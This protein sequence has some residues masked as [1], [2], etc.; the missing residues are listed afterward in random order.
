MKDDLIATHPLPSRPGNWWVINGKLV[1][2]PEGEAPAE[3]RG[4]KADESPLIENEN[5]YEPPPIA[6]LRPLED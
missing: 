5:G 3:A 4:G 6:A 1:E 2:L